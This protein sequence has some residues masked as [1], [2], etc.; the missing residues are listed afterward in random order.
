VRRLGEEVSSFV[1]AAVLVVGRL[2]ITIAKVF[3]V[4]FDLCVEERGDGGFERRLVVFGGDDEVAAA[5]GDL[6]ADVF[7]TAHGVDGDDAAREGDLLEELRYRGD[8]IGLFLGGDLSQGDALLAGP[9]ADDMQGAQAVGGVV[10]T[11]AGLAV[12]GDESIGRGVVGRDGVGDPIL[13]AALEGLGLE[14][15]EQS[16]NAIARGDTVGQ[17]EEGVQ[18]ILA[19]DSPA[20]N[21]GRSIAVAENAA[22]GDDDNVAQEVFAIACVPRIGKGTESKSRRIRHRRASP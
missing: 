9:G 18:P 19:I 11:A 15:D 4:A 3:K 20:M 14:G 5:Q 17:G 7:L 6:F 10:R 13:E 22:N 8:F 1:D 16:A 12:D 2:V 21:G